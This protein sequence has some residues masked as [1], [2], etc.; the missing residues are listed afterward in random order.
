MGCAAIVLQRPKVQQHLSASLYHNDDRV[1]VY[2]AA[3]SLALMLCSVEVYC[4]QI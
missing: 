2:W 1:S 3:L 4:S